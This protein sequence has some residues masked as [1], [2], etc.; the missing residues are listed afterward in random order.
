MHHNK[1]M[2]EKAVGLRQAATTDLN[3]LVLSTAFSST[4][5][6]FLEG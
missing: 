2:L 3:E 1:I 4:L 6:F 5:S